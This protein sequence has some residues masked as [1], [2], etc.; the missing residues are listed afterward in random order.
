MGR[1]ERTTLSSTL[2]IPSPEVAT[3]F[4]A[5]L[6]RDHLVSLASQHSQE[7]RATCTP[8]TDYLHPD[9]PGKPVLLWQ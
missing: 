5:P 9:I 8:Y 3:W 7:L 6:L 1:M 4:Q 2:P